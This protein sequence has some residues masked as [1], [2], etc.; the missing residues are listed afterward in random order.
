MVCLIT[1]R[2]RFDTRV[3]STMSF[4]MFDADRKES[5]FSQL[6]W[7]CLY[8]S[9]FSLEFLAFFA[10]L[11]KLLERFVKMAAIN[12]QRLNVENFHDKIATL[13]RFLLS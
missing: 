8:S 10:P 4:D 5:P 7:D 13:N 6:L 2:M 1:E 12:S 11:S 9:T 3:L